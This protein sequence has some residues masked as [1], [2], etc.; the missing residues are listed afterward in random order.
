[1][2]PYELLRENTFAAFGDLD[3]S[4][5]KAWI[6]VRHKEPAVARFFDYAFGRRPDEELYDVQNDP[7]E[8]RN[9]INDPAYAETAARLKQQLFEH[10]DASGGLNMPLL[11]DRGRQFYNRHPDRAAQA[12]FPDWFFDEPAPVTN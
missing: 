10:L 12:P 7:L 6:A 1:M 5:T 3:A 11:P 9:L 2:P 8:T 4:P